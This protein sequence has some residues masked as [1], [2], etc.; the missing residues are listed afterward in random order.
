MDNPFK[1]FFA[2]EDTNVI[3]IDIGSSAIKIVQLAKVHGKAVLKTYGSLALGPYA[4]VTIGQATNLPPEKIGEVI[5]DLIKEGNMTTTKGGVAIPLRSSLVSLIEMPNLPERE[6]NEMIP[7]EARKYIPVPV[8]EVTMDW[9]IIPKEEAKAFDFDPHP[10]QIKTDKSEVLVVSIHN[11]VLNN[12]KTIVDKSGVNAT[13]F[14]I[15]MFAAIRA[16]ATADPNP[17]MIMDMGAA[18]TKLYI[19]E[20]G[21]VKKSHMIN[22]GSQDI[23]LSIAQGLQI[24]PEKAEKLKRNLMQATPADMGAIYDMVDLTLDYIFSEAGTVLLAYQKR[25][26][27]SIGKVILTGGGIAMNGMLDYARSKLQ[28]EVILGDPFSKV[29]VPPFL[30]QIL[31]NTGLDFAVAVGIALR[32]L[33]EFE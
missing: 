4:G 33:Q 30:A 28:T 17:V 26:N 18:A 8:S 3:G 9:W 16:L 6:L 31:K 1:N 15:E 11:E 7:I 27:K 22:K 13:F 25:Y 2:K 21:I 24:P 14:E 29:Q 5:I 32:K 19:V 20:R 23:T 10:V 12:Y